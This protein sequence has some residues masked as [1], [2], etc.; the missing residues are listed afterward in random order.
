VGDGR[1]SSQE[2]ATLQHPIEATD[3]QINV[4]A[5]ELYGFREEEIEIVLILLANQFVSGQVR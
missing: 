1:E 5:Y 3:R 2:Q 4:L